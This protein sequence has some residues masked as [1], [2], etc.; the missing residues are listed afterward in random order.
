[1][2]AHEHDPA[3]EIEHIVVATSGATKLHIAHQGQPLCATPGDFTTK[4]LAAY[5]PA[6]REWC[7]YCL[8]L[9]QHVDVDAFPESV[10]N[11]PLTPP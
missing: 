6:H 4:P 3:D 5:P 11:D 1:M 10:S 8:E 2:T 9:W 7:Q